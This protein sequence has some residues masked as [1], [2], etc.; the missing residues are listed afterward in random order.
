MKGVLFLVWLASTVDLAGAL[1]I[2]GLRVQ[3]IM[4]LAVS[5]VLAAYL[6]LDRA[7]FSLPVAVAKRNI[8]LIAATLY[9]G[10]RC[11]DADNALYAVVDM[12]SLLL[13]LLI[14]TFVFGA[15]RSAGDASVI[16]RNA[17]MT[18][19]VPLILLAVGYFSGLSV[20]VEGVG[21]KGFIGARSVSLYCVT[22]LPIA[23]A[24][25]AHD[26]ASAAMKRLAVAAIFLCSA[27]ILVTLSR[28]ALLSALVMTVIVSVGTMKWRTML[29]MLVVV[30]VLGS[31]ALSWGP[32]ADRLIPKDSVEEAVQSGE[33]TSGRAALWTFVF[34]RGL[35][36][37]YFGAGTGNV[38]ILIRDNMRSSGILPHNE[39][40][41]FFYDGG[42]IGLLLVLIA[43]LSRAV[44]HFVEWR[45][46]VRRGDEDLKK[47]HLSAL[48]AT[49]SL[50]TA[51]LFDNVFLYQFMLCIA[52]TIFGVADKLQS[53]AIEPTR[54]PVAR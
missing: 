28:T 33:F 22:V 31:V 15:V 37:P 32:M 34:D 12:Q 47:W 13:P 52:F 17:L 51:G 38:K 7:F 44:H 14:V 53:G 49:A 42:V 45:R 50:M 21:Q 5:A 46:A 41:R 29:K 30:V 23:L 40:L 1:E 3:G 43:F 2:G 20:F 54:E 11:A 4:W 27:S 9:F 16:E 19:A 6:M 25:L 35:D 10:G 18:M 26:G 39:Y 8:W 36:H 24:V 48:L